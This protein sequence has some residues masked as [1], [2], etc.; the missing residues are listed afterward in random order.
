MDKNSDDNKYI[1]SQDEFNEMVDEF[2]CAEEIRYEKLYYLVSKFAKAHIVRLCNGSV[3]KGCGH[4]E[5]ILQI[6]LFNVSARALYG[7]FLK[8]DEN[9]E[10]M[11]RDENGSYKST[12]VLRKFLGYV[13]QTALRTFINYLEKEKRKNYI[14]IEDIKSDFGGKPSPEVPEDIAEKLRKAFLIVL[15]SKRSIYIKLTWL[16]HRIIFLQSNCSSIEANRL[17]M[18][19]FENSTLNNMYIAIKKASAIIPWL[20][21]NE[22]AINNIV[23]ELN[24][25][26]SWDK[27][28]CY[29]DVTYKEFYMKEKGEPSGEKSVSNWLYR[30]D[31]DIKEK[32]SDSSGTNKL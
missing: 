22:D 13:R 20:E 11:N 3:L 27:N 30:L 31:E 12:E 23:K 19:A 6:V 18:Q 2:V 14:S 24:K 9:G 10:F 32:S 28:K 17:L 25:P 26:C 1:I 21:I 29:A 7:F 8:K 16:A 4:E 15:S 5:D